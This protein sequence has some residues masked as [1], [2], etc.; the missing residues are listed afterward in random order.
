MMRRA[1][2][3]LV[4]QL[5]SRHSS[6]KRPLKLSIEPFCIGLP[7]SM[8]NSFTPWSWAQRSRSR[9]RSCQATSGSDPLATRRT[10][11]WGLVSRKACPGS[12]REGPAGRA[13]SSA[14][15]RP[16]GGTCGPT[17]ASRGSC[18]RRQLVRLARRLEQ[19][20]AALLAQPIAVA[21]DGDDV[22]V[23]EE[24]VEDRRRHHRIAE[25]RPPLADRTVARDQHAAALVAPR[26][27]LEEQVRGVGLE[28][29][30][31]ELVDD[32]EPRLGELGELVLEP[33][34][35]VRPGERRYQR[36]RLNEQDRVAGKDR[37]PPDRDGEVGL[38]DARRP[39]QQQR[40]AVGDEPAGCEIAD[41]LRVERG[42]G[43]EVEAGEVP[44]VRELRDRHRH[45]DPA[46]VLAG[47]L[48]LAEQGERLAQGQLALR[49]LVE[50]AVELIADRRQLE[51]GEH[52]LKMRGLGDH[53]QPPPTAASYSASGRKRAA[54]AGIDIGPGAVEAAG[55]RAGSRK[56]AIPSKWLGSNT[57][58]RRPLRSACTAISRPACRIRSRPPLISTTTPSPTSRHGTL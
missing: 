36:R 29:Q 6:R 39:E 16:A 52:L 51:P 1:S 31:A 38:A 17:W 26:D 45:L 4:N 58:C 5:W 32:E 3:R 53:D 47:D 57:R 50:Q 2:A 44:H 7:G 40:L 41:L 27:Q 24:A 37:G 22:A 11:P 33:S 12:P 19:A 18:G 15:R 43:F 48:P 20:G 42:L 30:V 34:L 23:M 46:L 56:P 8:K 13:P 28:R 49:G 10:D 21:A 9:P 55:A 35:A 54:G 25:H 14:R